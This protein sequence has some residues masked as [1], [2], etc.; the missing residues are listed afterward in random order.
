M[1]NSHNTG[2]EMNV[3]SYIAAAALSLMPLLS[4]ASVVYEWKSTNDVPPRGITFTLNF[5]ESAVR[6][7]GFSFALTGDEFEYFTPQPNL[8]LISFEFGLEG[9]NTSFSRQYGYESAP[10]YNVGGL[11][12]DVSFGSNG[13]MDG[14]IRMNSWQTSFTMISEGGVFTVYDLRSDGPVTGC[15]FMQETEC[16]GASGV[17]RR[18]DVPEPGSLALI[19]IGLFAASRMRR[20]ALR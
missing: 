20:K 1:A 7:G 10:G 14:F 19:G 16:T 5:E 6:S 15:D 13:F 18:T 9:A 2:V 8:G 11:E 12:M 17:I 4:Q 3:K